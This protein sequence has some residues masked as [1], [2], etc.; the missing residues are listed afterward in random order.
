MQVIFA[1]FVLVQVIRLKKCLKA[2][3]VRLDN[4]NSNN[5]KV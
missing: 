3:D 5:N 4:N 1:G 2:V